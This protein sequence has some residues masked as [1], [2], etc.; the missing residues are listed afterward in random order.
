MLRARLLVQILACLG[1][2]SACNSS[3]QQ[4]VEI[5]SADL[6]ASRS[7]LESLLGNEIEIV[8]LCGPAVGKAFYVDYNEQRW[9]DDGISKGR[10][11]FV[12]EQSGKHDLLF[13]DATGRY[14]KASD[15]GGEVRLIYTAGNGEDRSFSVIYPDTGVVETHNIT[16]D[17]NG[18][19]VDLWT[20]NKPVVIGPARTASFVSRCN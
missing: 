19:K 12:R 10:L 5:P 20:S 18:G 17:L 15:D 2:V 4:K 9:V 1:G 6:A 8:A 11:V 14:V 16:S 13:K 3:G 7:E